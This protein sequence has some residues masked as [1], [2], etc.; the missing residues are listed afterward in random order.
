MTSVRGKQLFGLLIDP[1]AARGLIGTETLRILFKEVLHPRNLVG[2]V[3][4]KTS[5]NAFS[6]I[7]AKAETSLGLVTF[8]IGLVGL[9]SASFSAD[10]IGDAASLCPGLVPLKSLI[11]LGCCMLFAYFPNGDGL[12]GIWNKPTG[13][14][15]PQRLHLTDSGHY[16][17]RIDKFDEVATDK[18]LQKG[19]QAATAP[20]SSM[21]DK[22]EA[23]SAA[24]FTGVVTLLADNTTEHDDEQDDSGKPVF[25]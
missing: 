1:G 22:Q 5:K 11:E 19:I 24:L 18:A 20:L 10:V 16:L 7:S 8:P 13:T 15:C 21:G 9:R 6:G 12:L 25:R 17:L 4:W 2:Q 14:W 23:Q 3:I